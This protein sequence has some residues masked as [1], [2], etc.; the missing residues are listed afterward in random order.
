VQNQRREKVRRTTDC[1]NYYWEVVVGEIRRYF[2][3]N[4]LLRGR[5]IISLHQVLILPNYSASEKQHNNVYD[6][7]TVKSEW[8]GG[9]EVDELLHPKLPCQVPCELQ[10]CFL[11]VFQSLPVTERKLHT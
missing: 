4:K 8:V 9:D 7:G 11:S 6:S 3:E 2:I 10:Y 1:D 5:E